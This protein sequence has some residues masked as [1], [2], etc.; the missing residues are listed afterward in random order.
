MT[1]QVFAPQIFDGQDIS[2]MQ[3]L[4]DGS[5]VGAGLRSAS[6]MRPHVP[7]TLSRHLR[8]LT[9]TIRLSSTA[10]ELLE[11]LQRITGTAG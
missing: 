8:R 10:S 3:V 6:N 4:V 9:V 5:V 7:A 11:V 1:V 2:E